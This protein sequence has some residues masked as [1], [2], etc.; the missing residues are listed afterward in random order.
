MPAESEVY[1]NCDGYSN[2][3]EKTT[4]K[5][6]RPFYIKGRVDFTRVTTLVEEIYLLQLGSFNGA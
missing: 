6:T 4:I 3:L 2:N 1:F 5:K